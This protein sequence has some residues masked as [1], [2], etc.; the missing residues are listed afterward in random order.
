[1]FSTQKL[2]NERGRSV[3]P[4]AH[5]GRAPQHAGFIGKDLIAGVQTMKKRIS[6]HSSSVGDDGM[7]QIG[8]RALRALK[9]LFAKQRSAEA[10]GP[11]DWKELE[12]FDL[13]WRERIEQMSAWIQ[14]CSTVV[15]LGCG[16][17]WLRDYITN[18]TYIP[19][20]YVSR[21][22]DTIVCDF[23]LREFPYTSADVCFVSGC[24]EYVEHPDWFISQIASHSN[25]GVLS[26]CCVEDFPDVRWRKAQGWK[27]HLSS[28]EIISKFRDSGMDL[29]RRAYTHSRNALFMF[30]QR[31]PSR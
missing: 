4:A 26:Y 10:A 31:I 12:Y 2:R 15:D 14:P 18:C 25:V 6:V 1:M 9:G 7:V 8:M 19:V 28:E 20:D 5:R 21:S 17:Q 23:N 16:K 11:R 27:N 30:S 22:S 29:Q 13:A 24:L 3:A